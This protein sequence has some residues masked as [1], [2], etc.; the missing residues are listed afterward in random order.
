[1]I[2]T[3]RDNFFAGRQWRTLE[4]LNAQAD[5]WCQGVSAA[6]RCPENNDLTVEEAFLQEQPQLL[7]LPDNPFDT[8]EHKVVS[9]RK[10]PY[11]RFDRNDYSIPHQQVQKPLTV[12]ASLSTVCI[13]DGDERIAEHPRSFDQGRQIEL[14]S[15]INTLWL[16][17]TNARLHRGQD[18]LLNEFL[19]HYGREE[20]HAA[21]TEALEQ[22]SPYPQAV[23]QILERR[24]E[25][26]QQP[27]PVAVAVPDKVRAINVKTA[28]IA[29]YDNLYASTDSEEVERDTGDESDLE[30]ETNA[31]EETDLDNESG[32]GEDNA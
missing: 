24:R 22:Q 30:E 9:A 19:D 14:E 13:L 20:L 4:E 28:D 1:A 25:E 29:A 21:V 10:T 12:Q 7:A 8:A 3:I 32:R 5:A 16:E 17:K 27:P 31:A 18:R 6:R 15:H 23:Q 26:K 2:R 11:I